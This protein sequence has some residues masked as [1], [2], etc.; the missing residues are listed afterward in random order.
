[1]NIHISID[2]QWLTLLD[3]DEVVREYPISSSAK[4]VGFTKDSHRTPTGQFRVCEKIGYEEALGAVF[5]HRK[6]VGQWTP[7]DVT[8][9]D[10]ITSR[11]LR[12]DGLEAVNKNTLDRCIYIHGTNHEELIGTPASE[13][14]I[15]MSNIDV[16]ELFDLTPLDTEV[17][18]EP[19][20]RRRGKIAFFDCDSTLSTIEGIDEL[21]R[22][23]GPEIFD[24]IVSLTNAGMN[25][26]IPLHEVFPRRMEILKP[27]RTTCD[28]VAQRYIDTI[29]PGVRETLQTLRDED[30]TIV[31]ISGGFAPLIEPLARELGIPF[32]EAV[33][34]HHDELGNY[35]G[36]GADYPTTRNGGKPQI[37]R[38]WQQALM[39]KVTMMVGDGISD[40]ETQEAVDLFVGFGGVIARDSVKQKS[41]HFITS[42]GDLLPLAKSLAKKK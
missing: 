8:A 20:T 9:A 1:M 31:I 36:Y 5:K 10:L 14:C 15:R 21:A 17:I 6:K 7:G 39:P 11:I 12:L 33:P 37:I 22:A 26:S 3:G 41:E 19:P 29:V 23:R 2:D 30:W 40:W 38:E 13:G 35:M 28:A 27:D 4:G 24:Q 25:G 34:L 32:V 16:I 42:F 18:I